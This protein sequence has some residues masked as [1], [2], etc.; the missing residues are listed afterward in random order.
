M[1]AIKA[2]GLS[3]AVLTTGAVVTAL[4]HKFRRLCGFVAFVFMMASVAPLFYVVSRVMLHGTVESPTPLFDVYPFGASLLVR[5]DA[6]SAF[7]LAI[8]AFL[9]LLA[10]LYSIDYI[11]HKH[12]ERESL[13]RYYPFLFLFMAGMVGVVVVWDAFFFLIAWEFMT[14]STYVLVVFEKENP[15][16]LRAGLKYFVLTHIGTACL[17][18]SIVILRVWGG[19]FGFDSLRASMSLMAVKKAFLL[20]LVL[21]L[22]F[23]G[24]GTKAAI[25]PFGDWLPDA[26]PAAPSAISAI[27]SGV[28]IKM[29]VYGILRYLVW[30]APLSH[31]LRVWGEIVALFGV[32]TLIICSVTAVAENDSKRMLA[33]SS[34]AQMGY[35]WL[36]LGLGMAFLR[37]NPTLSAIGFLAGLYHVINHACFKGLLFFNAGSLL[38]QVGTRDLGKMGGLL[39]LMPATSFSAIVAALSIS[40]LPPFN[41]FV[42]KWLIYQG[43]ILGGLEIPLFLAFAVL[44][45]FTS[46]VTLAYM[47][48]FVGSAFLGLRSSLCQGVEEAPIT[49]AVPQILLALVC[50]GLGVV[51]VFPLL[52][53]H[54]A[55]E[56]LKPLYFPQLEALFVGGKWQLSVN[57]GEGISALW[58]PVVA[59]VALLVCSLIAWLIYRVSGAP[60]REVKVW[61]CGEEHSSEEIRF[62]APG[63]YSPFQILISFRVGRVRVF[64]LYPRIPLPKAGRLAE[65]RKAFDFDRLYYRMVDMGRRICEKFSAVHVGYPQ[66]YVLWM[67]LGLILAII[68]IFALT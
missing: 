66:V 31:H 45:L 53:S 9:G 2:I 47:L 37:V 16:N 13:L 11:S 42:S 15:I 67:I 33:F 60:V 1:T 44:A 39:L 8:I 64:S 65:L 14:L 59:V 54:K 38:R 29:G 35:I 43:A 40:G 7:F 63:F 21:L 46:I 22:F 41:G 3:F 27:L 28:M 30:M 10:T 34:M 49:M 32:I 61:A 25:F 57:V 4:L 48:K 36:G 24:F 51:P 62:K 55:V 20:H 18:A 23:V 19:A 26:H 6:L 56:V 68:V 52:V 50:L 17:I 58:N 12:Y 5:V